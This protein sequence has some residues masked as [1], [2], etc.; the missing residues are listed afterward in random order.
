MFRRFAIFCGLAVAMQAA[1]P[2]AAQGSSWP[3]RPV[4]WIVGYAAGGTTDIIARTLAQALSEQTGQ[5]FVVEN[6][7]G[8]N[9]NIG[10]EIVTRAAPDGYTFYVGSTANAINRTLYKHLNYDVVKD[11]A[12]VALLGTVP[13]LL[14]VNPALPVKSVQDYIEYAKAN[15]GKLTCAS[16]G[17]GSAI[18]M[19]CE[20]FKLQTGTNILHVPYRGSGP[21]MTDLLGGQVDSIFDNMP[22]VLPNVQAGKLRALGVTT[23]D[24]SP[25]APDI[26]TLA[27]SGLPDFSVQSWFGL[28]APAATDAA[29]VQ[30]MNQAVNKALASDTVRKVFDQRGVA[31]PKPPNAAPAFAG[32]VRGE[33]EKWAGVVKQSGAQ[34]E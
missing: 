1:G 15:P 3:A 11:F 17:T 28:F 16:S 14:V 21:A 30:Q 23:A 33:V 5:T 4:T 24:R 20:L 19:S 9:S 31:L 13:N 29:I 8:A 10:A 6:R 26:P 32:F 25:S 34:V 22:T 12:S 2:A 27:E 18:H 7:T